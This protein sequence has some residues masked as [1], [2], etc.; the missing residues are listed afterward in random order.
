MGLLSFA[1]RSLEAVAGKERADTILNKGREIMNVLPGFSRSRIA[2]TLDKNQQTAGIVVEPVTAVPP[3]PTDDMLQQVLR[4][5]ET[6]TKKVEAVSETYGFK[7]ATAAS[8]SENHP[9][10]SDDRG[11][12]IP[13]VAIGVFDGVSHGGAGEYAAI[14]GKELSE[15]LLPELARRHKSLTQDQVIEE[16]KRIMGK[17]NDIILLVSECRSD[18]DRFVPLISEALTNLVG[19]DSQ[20]K[21]TIMQDI[22]LPYIEG[23][24]KKPN[25]TP[26]TD[27]GGMST[28]AAIS[29]FYN[30]LAITLSAGD[31]TIRSLEEDERGG[32]TLKT[33]NKPHNC[34]TTL[35][36]ILKLNSGDE[37]KAQRIVS[38]F[39]NLSNDGKVE[40]FVQS[41]EGEYFIR[42]FKALIKESNANNNRWCQDFKNEMALI[43]RNGLRLGIAAVNVD[44]FSPKDLIKKIIGLR[45]TISFQ[46]G[47]GANSSAT[48][49]DTG[50]TWYDNI[51]VGTHALKNIKVIATETD[52]LECMTTDEIETIYR[53]GY[54]SGDPQNIA[55]GLVTEAVAT[56]AE[57]RNPLLTKSDDKTNSVAFVE[58]QKVD[59]PENQQAFLGNLN[60]LM[61]TVW[62][63]YDN[64]KEVVGDPQMEANVL[65]TY[66]TI[67]TVLIE[68]IAFN[69]ILPFVNEEISKALLL[70]AKE[71]LPNTQLIIERLH[72]LNKSTTLEKDFANL[73][74][75]FYHT[76]PPNSS[77]ATLNTTLKNS[78]ISAKNPGTITREI[79]ADL[80]KEQ[81]LQKKIAKVINTTPE[82]PQ[83]REQLE[84]L[85]YIL[86]GAQY[87]SSKERDPREYYERKITFIKYLC[88]G[89]FKNIW[90]TA[91]T[92]TSQDFKDVC[93]ELDESLQGFFRQ[94]EN[95]RYDDTTMASFPFPT[96]EPQTENQR[97]AQ[98]RIL[99]VWF[100]SCLDQLIQKIK[101]YTDVPVGKGNTGQ[102]VQPKSTGKLNPIAAGT[103]DNQPTDEEIEEKQKKMYEAMQQAF[104][105]TVSKDKT[106]PFQT[107]IEEWFQVL[108]L[109]IGIDISDQDKT[110]QELL[111]Q[112]RELKNNADR[113]IGQQVG[114]MSWCNHESNRTLIAEAIARQLGQVI[115]PNPTES[116][117]LSPAISIK[118]TQKKT[119]SRIGQW[120]A[121]AGVIVTLSI[122]AFT[123]DK[124]GSPE[125]G[126]Q[127]PDTTP[128]VVKKENNPPQPPIALN[129]GKPVV[130]APPSPAPTPQPSPT[131]E[132]KVVPA[133][134]PTIIPDKDVPV[135]PV[136]PTD[137]NTGAEV[138][139]NMMTV[140]ERNQLV[141]IMTDDPHSTLYGSV[142]KLKKTRGATQQTVNTMIMAA[143]GHEMTQAA[144]V[145]NWSNSKRKRVA[146]RVA[147]WGYGK[148]GE[149]TRMLEN[150]QNHVDNP[151]V[152]QAA[153]TSMKNGDIIRIVVQPTSHTVAKKEVSFI[154]HNTEKIPAG[155]NIAYTEQN[156]INDASTLQL[157]SNGGQETIH[158]GNNITAAP[159]KETSQSQ[160]ISLEQSS[161]Q[162][163]N[164]SIV[165]HL[166]ETKQKD[167]DSILNVFE[168]VNINKLAEAKKQAV[169]RNHSMIGKSLEAMG[170]EP[171]YTKAS[172]SLEI[173]RAMPGIELTKSAEKAVR[174]ILSFVTTPEEL[175]AYIMKTDITPEV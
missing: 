30:D 129:S 138:P 124:W 94:E 122:G 26:V 101:F 46:L 139:E 78:F 126:K 145:A 35:I 63:M 29:Y 85:V 112:L 160:K 155:T 82:G 128:P 134:A 11:F 79:Q 143:D 115:V 45:D 36:K 149:I 22:V 153:L 44:S 117:E 98:N 162:Y 42:V 89:Y 1:K 9:H 154:P 142:K 93:H 169:M 136:S 23:K 132:N 2:A 3:N 40:D 8:A 100:Q 118:E 95:N 114:F 163:P 51:D 116:G 90:E 68:L 144:G 111:R 50:A 43:K 33:L 59:S 131:A 70:I 38:T 34:A 17:I 102:L 113:T 57:N 66:T 58:A 97:V 71:P 73:L 103:L 80:T 54:Q 104:E 75:G 52:G 24:L 107:I 165:F 148:T 28:T 140:A 37:A 27:L 83:V 159:S 64:P 146:K 172:W 127:N 171:P 48:D 41:E 92:S 4:Q 84:Q 150:P 166:N 62:S 168:H 39:F 76:Y 175:A 158:I 156:R 72:Q 170:F 65:T 49:P 16:L 96:E 6:D 18:V 10:Y 173:F 14:I 53:N 147:T 21:K 60:L 130:I 108:E 137:K 110:I 152:R 56:N 81:E 5:V 31:S 106:G 164:K 61:E 119:R 87:L 7:M 86:S 99:T 74:A 88:M 125:K 25:G 15:V 13:G 121:A 135:P 19:K 161:I 32:L 120:A 109:T 20:A 105:H 133:P 141:T 12:T 55:N 174:A 123:L 69:S 167:I 151:A 77:T 47:G 91:D 157:T 67:R